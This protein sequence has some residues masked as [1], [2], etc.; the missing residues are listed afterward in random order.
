MDWFLYDIGLRRERVKGTLIELEDLRNRSMHSTL[1]FKNIRKEHHETWGDT[2][3]T[4][5]HFIISELNKPYSYDDIDLLISRAH[6]GAENQEDLEEYQRK[7]SKGPR[8]IFAQFTNCDVMLNAKK[9]TKVVVNQMFSN[10]LT[11][12]RNNALKR[13]RQLLNNPDN[14]LQVKLVY[15]ATLKSEQKGSRDRR[16]TLEIH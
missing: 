15:L 10:D 13:Q 6:R 16:E 3:K 9:Q 8:P 2:C 12:R 5:S 4:L 1:V 7:N 14:D 11:I